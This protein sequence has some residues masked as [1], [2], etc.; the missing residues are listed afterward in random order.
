MLKKCTRLLRAAHF[1]VKIDL[2]WEFG[3]WKGHW[4]TKHISK[5]KSK[6]KS[7]PLFWRCNVETHIREKHW[8]FISLL[9]FKNRYSTQ[10]Y[11]TL[12][13]TTSLNLQACTQFCIAH[14]Q[15]QLTT[16]FFY[17]HF[18][19]WLPNPLRGSIKTSGSLCNLNQCFH[20]VI[21]KS[22]ILFVHFS[23]CPWSWLLWQ[24]EKDVVSVYAVPSLQNRHLATKSTWVL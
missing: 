24:P 22:H 10:Q 21:A 6:K 12:H 7:R 18:A 17:L 3:W 2:F 15:E 9:E 23:T 4:G 13:H 8:G 5:S 20:M 11:I 19:V 14:N 16:W 1:Q